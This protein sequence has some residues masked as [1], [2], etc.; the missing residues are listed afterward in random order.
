MLFMCCLHV[1]LRILLT[2]LRKLQIMIAVIKNL[3]IQISQQAVLKE[4]CQIIR[5]N[6][7]QFYGLNIKQ[8]T[9]ILIKA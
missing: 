2:F 6:P 1:A 9:D 3:T 7:I 5:D 4:Q 8:R